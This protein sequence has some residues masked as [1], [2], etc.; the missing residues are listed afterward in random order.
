MGSEPTLTEKSYSMLDSCPSSVGVV[1]MNEFENSL[2]TSGA[3]LFRAGS[4]VGGDGRRCGMSSTHR[5]VGSHLDEVT[6]LGRQLATQV[7]GEEVQGCLKYRQ[8]SQLRWDC[9]RE[10]L[11]IQLHPA[12]QRR[13]LPKLG[14]YGSR[15]GVRTQ[16]EVLGQFVEASQLRWDCAGKRVELDAESIASPDESYSE[17]CWNRA[18]ESICPGKMAE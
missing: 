11:L 4:L 7:Q 9:T 14:R 5:E 1:P 10:L 17:L 12:C 2:D 15:E 8:A 16:H 13:N 18:V 6:D 3:R